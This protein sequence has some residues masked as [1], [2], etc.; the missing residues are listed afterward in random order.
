MTF[1][2]REKTIKIKFGDNIVTLTQEEF[3]EGMT[4]QGYLVHSNPN[5]VKAHNNVD[6]QGLDETPNS[7][8]GDG[9][10]IVLIALFSIVILLPVFVTIPS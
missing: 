6:L 4:M 2:I 1:Y 10:K 7:G 5:A 3:N 8:E 9:I